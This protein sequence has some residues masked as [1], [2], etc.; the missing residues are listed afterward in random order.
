MRHSTGAITKP[1]RPAELRDYLR[2]LNAAGS[3]AI[4]P[5]RH[6]ALFEEVF[7]DIDRLEE[8]WLRHEKAD[9]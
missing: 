1:N 9:G 3:G 7:G 5:D 2:K 6:E 4:P 8:A